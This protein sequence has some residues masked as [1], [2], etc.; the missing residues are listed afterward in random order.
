MEKKQQRFRWGGSQ[1]FREKSD[2][3]LQPFLALPGLLGVMVGWLEVGVLSAAAGI[4]ALAIAK[5]DGES[6]TERGSAT[7]GLCCLLPLYAAGEDQV[8]VK[9]APTLCGVAAS[10]WERTLGP[11]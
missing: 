11:V 10:V 2:D 9:G 4:L 8:A 1:K 5:E 6:D 3:S 7:L